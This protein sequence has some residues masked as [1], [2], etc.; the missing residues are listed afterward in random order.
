VSP[1]GERWVCIHGHFYQPPRE[2]PW[3]GAIEPQ[4]SA[5]P[6]PDW[7]ARITA[8]CYRPNAWARIVDGHGQITAIVDNYAR[9]SFDV[10]PTLMTWLAR[11]A[12]EVHDAIVAADRKGCAQ[13]DGHGPAMAQAYHHL[14]MPLASPR[15]RQTQVRWGVRDFEHRFGRRPEGMWLP[16]CA[17]DTATLEA[18]V[19][20]GLT[21]T[22]LAPHQAAKLRPPGGAWRDVTHA[23]PGRTYRCPLPSGRAIDLFFYDG[24]LSRAVAFDKLLDDGGLLARRLAASDGS[25]A[26]ATVLRHIA[27]DGETY[28]HHHRYGDMALAY[29][30]TVIDRGDLPGARLTTYG[31]FRARH[32]ATWEVAIRERTSWSC[33]HGVERWRADCGCNAGSAGWNQRWRAPLRTALDELRARVEQVI[34]QAAVGLLTDPWAA[35]DEYVD[36]VLDRGRTDEL[37]RRHAGRALTGDERRRALE[38]LELGRHAMLM[39]TSCGWFF[40]DLAGIET[41]QILR[42]AARACELAAALG[43]P[44]LED[45]LLARLAAATSN[46]PEVGDGRALWLTQVAPARV[47]LARLVAHHAIVL[48]LG[49]GDDRDTTIYGHRI[50]ARMLVRRRRGALRLALGRV[51]ITSELTGASADLGYAALYQGRLELH[52]RVGPVGDDAEWAARVDRVVT[53]F[54]RQEVPAIVAALDADPV[55]RRFDLTALCGRERGQV[56]DRVLRE[57]QA[58]VSDTLQRLYDEQAELVRYLVRERLPVPPLLTTAAQQVLGRR[59]REELARPAPRVAEIRACLA[60]AAQLEIDL[61]TPEVAF[62]TGAALHRA[63]EAL[64]AGPDD[65]AELGRLAQ[66]AELAGA[67]KSRVDLWDAQNAAWR[68]RLR[69]L[70]AWRQRAAAGD[71]EAARLVT[72]FDRL[73]R[74]LRLHP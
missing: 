70:P 36:A 7:N 65:A 63:V 2:H 73:A 35:R 24:G 43:A 22:V 46:R 71:A 69:A 31:Q 55:S 37:L 26:G 51:T 48:V 62:A 11:E 21:F 9:M 56:I 34:D 72:G 38:L 23:E 15:D 6:Y 3:L 1:P 32:P 50:V 60:E 40:D 25:P 59:L 16:E 53:A 17:V 74:A 39:F 67:M 4:P 68:W 54:D 52:G 49:D 58:H 5:A 33:A 30:L 27:T 42:Y 64:D 47:D 44:G 8:E 14:I 10:G 20:E 12:A 57:A 61:D 18:L 19:D 66:M 28:G 41:V 13:F 29:A 45:E